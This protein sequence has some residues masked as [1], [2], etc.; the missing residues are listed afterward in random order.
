[1]NGERPFAI[2]NHDLVLKSEEEIK[3]EDQ[4]K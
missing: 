3:R 2:F 4:E 1:M